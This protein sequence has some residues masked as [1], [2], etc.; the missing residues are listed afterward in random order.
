MKPGPLFSSPL[1]V[2][3]LYYLYSQPVLLLSTSRLLCRSRISSYRSDP[4]LF[5]AVCL[6]QS[7]RQGR[8]CCCVGVDVSLV[9]GSSSF[10]E[11]GHFRLSLFPFFFF[12]YKPLSCCFAAGFLFSDLTAMTVSSAAA[13]A[14]IRY[15]RYD[16][17]TFF[18]FDLTSV[19]PLDG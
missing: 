2:S 12:L 13:A 16:R 9:V 17:Y 10:K 19:A 6:L 8:P 15:D 1:I 14:A 4:C 11:L 5:P 7:R 18:C 3:P